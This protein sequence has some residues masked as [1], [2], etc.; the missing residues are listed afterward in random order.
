MLHL[1]VFISLNIIMLYRKRLLL[2]F[3]F[4]VFTSFSQK[5]AQNPVSSAVI[6]QGITL[7][8][9]AHYEQAIALYNTI[10]D[11]DDRYLQALYEKVLSYNAWG[12]YEKAQKYALEG[13]ALNQTELS[14]FYMNLGTALDEMNQPEKAIEVFN[15]GIERF[16]YNAL[17]Y[18][19]RAVTYMKMEKY[20]KTLADLKHSVALNPFHASSHYH[21]SKFALQ[22][23]DYSKALMSATVYYLIEPSS[24]RANELL[25]LLDKTLVGDTL[26][27]PRGIKLSQGDNFPQINL[28]IKNRVALDNRYEVP[29]EIP[30]NI[31][32]QTYLVMDKCNY[33]PKDLG[34]WNQ[35][36]L[37]FLDKILHEKKFDKL[38]N[39]ML[40]SSY[41]EN[42]NKII[43]KYKYDDFFAWCAAELKKMPLPTT[44]LFNG[45]NYALKSVFNKELD[46]AAL[47]NLDP[48]GKNFRGYT[49]FL[50]SSGGILAHGIFNEKGE[51]EGVWTWY[52]DNGK[53]KDSIFFN[54]GSYDGIYMSWYPN[55]QVSTQQN[56]K[57]GK[58]D[59]YAVVYSPSGAIQRD[60]HYKD[61]VLTDTLTNYYPTGAVKE[62]Y[63]IKNGKKEGWYQLFFPDGTLE[64]TIFYKNDLAEN[65]YEDYYHNRQL[66][67]KVSYKNN[68]WNGPYTSWYRDGQLQAE[69][70]YSDGEVTGTW[71]EYY[72]DGTLE[73]KIVYQDDSNSIKTN[74]SPNGL[75]TSLYNLKKDKITN[76][77]FF[78]K[79]GNVI[80]E[81]NRSW[82]K[83]DYKGYNIHGVVVARGKL[84]DNNQTGRWDFFDDN[85]LLSWNENFD[86]EGLLEG[87]QKKYY[88]HGQVSESYTYKKDTLNGYYASYYPS[89]K[90][91]H[92]GYYLAGKK[93]GKWYEYNAFGTLISSYYYKDDAFNGTQTYYYSDRTRKMTEYYHNGLL[94]SVT[95]FAN[96]SIS[97][98][99][100]LANGTGIARAFYPNG[101]KRF[102]AE[103]LNGIKHGPFI[104]YYGNGQISTKGT[105][106]NNN[107][108]GEWVWFHPNGKK[109][110]EATY[111]MGYQDGPVVQYYDN[112]Q[113]SETYTYKNR[114]LE[115]E[116]KYFNRQGHLNSINTYHYGKLH[117]HKQFFD[118]TTGK[119]NHIRYYNHGRVV[120]Y[121]SPDKPL[122]TISLQLESGKIT[123]RYEN[124]QMSRSYEIDK[125]MLTGPYQEYYQNGQLMEESIYK[126]NK[127]HGKR[128]TYYP[129]GNIKSEASY[130]W[131]NLEGTRLLYYPNGKLRKKE[132]YSGNKLNGVVEEYNQSGKLVQKYRYKDGWLLEELKI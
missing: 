5:K 56:Y 109:E 62:L 14:G 79:E 54:N 66:Y 123:A 18:F 121:I 101:Q 7:Y 35:L 132:P 30:I 122:D 22:E 78:D 97:H 80:V 113:I 48:S 107:M 3:L 94:L 93:H 106:F 28:L 52:Y 87:I 20:E 4:T 125:G 39:I 46:L 55:G 53:T 41:N 16:P 13:L 63:P 105:Y 33:N 49:K 25:L 19:N 124:G 130:V 2:L 31:I 58:S 45:K 23:G 70:T 40:I 69:G 86:E 119:L 64:Y 126:A 116:N 73:T 103:Y 131:G 102:E 1:N 117:G 36:Y 112:G 37:P 118:P 26:L 104:R 12:K 129:D 10:A 98:I 71:K 92:Q 115:G 82:G 27:K 42:F 90:I 77:K 127:S 81:G 50:N 114:E 44:V 89:G 47:G 91:H 51:K 21:L 11:G 17:L 15:Q 75:K 68:F 43:E 65:L 74:Y 95:S 34:F 85:G 57:N 24:S 96:D 83:I 72:P 120:G 9:S 110:M 67:R 61:G 60:M 8:D 111:I 6:Q 108:I 29:S 59:G 99:S 32:K 76:Y 128:T 84:K 100:E 88:P 38:S